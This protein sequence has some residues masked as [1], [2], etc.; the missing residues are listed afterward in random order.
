M[1][2]GVSPSFQSH[3]ELW[4]GVSLLRRL[5]YAATVA[6]YKGAAC[7]LKSWESLCSAARPPPCRFLLSSF[8]ASEPGEEELTILPSLASLCQENAS[9]RTQNLVQS[10]TIRL[11]GKRARS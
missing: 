1:S 9:A 7:I 5:G 4:L 10:H 8:H 2:A 6:A 3:V 11:G